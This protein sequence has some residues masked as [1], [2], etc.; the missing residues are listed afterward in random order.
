MAVVGQASSHNPQ[1]IQREKLIRKNSGYQRPSLCSAFC[2]EIQATGQATAHRLQA[3]QRSSP[4]GSR[5]NTIRPRN[6]GG[7]LTGTSG[8]ICVSRLLN[9][10]MPI[11]QILRNWVPQPKTNSFNVMA[12]PLIERYTR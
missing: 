3:T 11:I 5:V 1:K 12:S 8:Y 7:G 2:N 6:R 10:C 9:A 4:S